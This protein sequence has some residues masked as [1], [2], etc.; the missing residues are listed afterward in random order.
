MR[1]T[2]LN[3]MSFL[4]QALG[5]ALSFGLVACDGDDGSE[6]ADTNNATE[7]NG[8]GDGDATGDGDGDGDGCVE[9][10][11]QCLRF[12]ECIGA[13]VPEQQPAVEAQ[14]GAEGSCWCDG[15]DAANECFTTCVQQLDTAITNNPT[16]S[17]CHASSCS[18]DELDP[19]EPYGPIVGG[20]CSDW[21]GNPQV[22]TQNLFGIAGGFCSP[23]CGGIAKSCPEHSQTSAKGT[24]GF[25]SNGVEQCMSQ[26]WVDPT[27]IGGTQCQCGATCQPSGGP[28]GEGNLRGICTFE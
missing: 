26:C 11:E 1:K 9:P 5:L 15:V 28:D 18:L 4:A 3:S 14:Y 25:V 19:A 21:N 10:P 17:A 27:I 24:C 7:S 23:A 16:E 13:I 2:R 6:M 12:V 8:D 22:P 20:A